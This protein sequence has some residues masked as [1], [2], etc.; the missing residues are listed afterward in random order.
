MIGEVPVVGPA[1]IR[2]PA[3]RCNNTIDGQHSYPAGA[4]ESRL[5]DIGRYLA[6]ARNGSK[7]S[8]D[9]VVARAIR[10]YIDSAG[11]GDKKSDVA[12]KNVSSFEEDRVAIRQKWEGLV[13]LVN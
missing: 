11:C 5:P 6:P 2:I 7:A 8:D 10:P 3:H 13:Q 1:A 4:V 9:R 12:V